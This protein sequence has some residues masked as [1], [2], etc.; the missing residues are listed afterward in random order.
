MNALL[1]WLVRLS[2][3]LAPA[4]HR[5]R[6]G[7]ELAATV[8]AL[9]GEARA[10]GRGV[11]RGYLLQ[12]LADSLRESVRL[13]RSGETSGR[14]LATSFGEAVRDDL[15]GSARR[16]RQRPIATAGVVVTLAAVVTAVTT[17]FALAHAVLW[18]ALPLPDAERLVFVWETVQD[19]REPFRVTSGRF[20]SL[21]A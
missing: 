9:A 15:R 11:E 8:N 21:A 19:G 16:W 14:R 12:E 20:A 2:L 5:E 13:W 3:R 4:R 1:R 7:G 17:T 6:F 18:K 10:R